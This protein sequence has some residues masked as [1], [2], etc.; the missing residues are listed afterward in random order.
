MRLSCYNGFRE[1]CD[2]FGLSVYGVRKIA[3]RVSNVYALISLAEHVI[4]GFDDFR[5]RRHAESG[6]THGHGVAEFHPFERS[7][8]LVFLRLP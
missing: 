2:F 5:G 3:F 4:D 8:I 1:V 7:D 6:I